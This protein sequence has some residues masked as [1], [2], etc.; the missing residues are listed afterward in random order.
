MNG[1][2]KTTQKYVELIR[3]RRTVG[4]DL[5]PEKRPVAIRARSIYSLLL[6]ILALSPQTASAANSNSRDLLVNIEK[7]TPELIAA[8]ARLGEERSVD[9][10]AQ[11]DVLQLVSQYCG[12]ANARRYYLSIFISANADNPEIKSGKTILEAPA[13]I[14]IP[15]CLFAQD[16]LNA[17]KADGSGLRL[18]RPVEISGGVISKV[19]ANT[20][21]AL[22][23]EKTKW[24]P[25]K[26]AAELGVT[27]NS[28]ILPGQG[29]D[30]ARLTRSSA[31]TLPSSLDG[32]GPSLVNKVDSERL[33]DPSLSAIYSGVVKSALASAFTAGAQAG[34][35]I[36]RLS[37]NSLNSN[38]M[39]WTTAFERG[40]RTQDILAANQTTNLS[41]MP[42][43]S[44][45]L[46]SDVAPG[47]YSSVSLKPNVT[48]AEAAQL[49]AS[50][51]PGT[52]QG[53]A[54]ASGYGSYLE[55]PESTDTADCQPGPSAKWPIDV[56]ELKTVLSYRAAATKKPNP[57]GDFL[58]F[59]TGFP[60]GQENT[61]PFKKEFF[62]QKPG[63]ISDAN[64]DPYLWTTIHP[65]E[66]TATQYYYDGL[67]TSAHGVGVLTLALGGIEI[68]NSQLLSSDVVSE[69][70]YGYVMS[71]MGYKRENGSSELTVD[72]GGAMNTLSG[73]NFGR[74]P[75]VGVNLSLD[76]NLD[77]IQGDPQT[78][79]K[80]RSTVLFVFAA[81]NA[82]GEP[83]GK[84]VS[85]PPT[86]Q[87]ASW[88]G[89][90]NKNVITVGA[91]DSQ[92]KYWKKSNW[93]MT[94]VDIA[95]PGCAVPTYSWNGDTKK[96][97]TVSLSGTSFAAPLVSF[98]ANLLH[99]GLPDPAVI[100]SRILYSG[101]YFSDLATKV[102][103]SRML[104]VPTALA[105]QFDAIRDGSGKL[106]LGR[107]DWPEAGL[108]FCGSTRKKDDVAQLS[109]VDVIAGSVNPIYRDRTDP[110]KISFAPICRLIH[111]ELVDRIIFQEAHL[112]GNDIKLDPVRRSLD[113]HD[114]RSITPCE[115]CFNFD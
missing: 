110:R 111:G 101:R 69:S 43:G 38:A 23:A 68:L 71:L 77:A 89:D 99:G 57:A 100:K 35:I 50:L 79:V 4:F 59:D 113:Y 115:T 46:S 15:A 44:A 45:I 1:E 61:A 19:V 104:D 98:A 83:V 41:N 96:F 108:E 75:V 10:P 16:S 28:P 37:T 88:G 90:G 27:S 72:G 20:K 36:P 65:P 42:A 11:T 81:G 25:T 74:V 22:S 112:I 109:F 18:D 6:A 40:L 94:N 5:C 66:Y 84:N 92:G 70:G 48:A 114:V 13:K 95:A 73:R 7:L 107:I 93:S 49:L 53:A 31:G 55:A 3:M 34:N 56:D 62:T 97:D 51:S 52:T 9:V 64:S 87:P 86:T 29:I 102:R 33:S 12:S 58:V 14:K 67:P 80:D 60:I 78:L 39:Q 21:S 85:D 24:D 32:F 106:L 17:V 54:L 103:S 2:A 8:V 105:F 63:G 91:A 47:T 26:V 76:F 30:F 82:V